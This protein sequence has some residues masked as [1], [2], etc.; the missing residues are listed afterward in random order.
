MLE[1]FALGSALLAP[2][3]LAPL[4]GPPYLDKP[5][6]APGA[7]AVGAGGVGVFVPRTVSSPRPEPFTQFLEM[8]LSR[9]WGDAG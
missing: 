6:D 1:L 7:V 2:L 8:L 3:V 5:L 4:L 9:L